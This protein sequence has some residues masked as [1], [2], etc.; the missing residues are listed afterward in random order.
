MI[1]HEISAIINDAEKRAEELLSANKDKL[2]ALANTLIEE[3]T[4]DGKRVDEIIG[5]FHAT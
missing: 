3:E 1:D 2:D 5:V 4:L